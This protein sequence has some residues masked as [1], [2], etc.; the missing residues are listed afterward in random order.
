MKRRTLTSAQRENRARIRAEKLSGVLAWFDGDCDRCSNPILVQESQLVR[1]SK[2][3]WI[4]VGCAAG[5]DD[6]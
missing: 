4:H 5:Q 6:E 2:G 3:R 1:D